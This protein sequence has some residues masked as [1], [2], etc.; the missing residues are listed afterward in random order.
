[1]PF[2]IISISLL[3]TDV[4]RQMYV[5]RFPGF[6]NI[7]FIIC[8]IYII[9]TEFVL[10]FIYPNKII[11]IRIRI[12]TGTHFV[13]SFL[14]TLTSLLYKSHA[15]ESTLAVSSCFLTNLGADLNWTLVGCSSHY[16]ML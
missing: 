6:T 5:Y 1:M 15:N 12:V 11:C 2:L 13:H 9:V 3:V 16:I 7:M 14:K 8:I 4:P 10:I